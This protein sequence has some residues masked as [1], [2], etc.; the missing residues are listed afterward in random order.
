M[1]REKAL[2]ELKEIRF[3]LNYKVNGT[4]RFDEAL[5]MAIEILERELKT[6]RW[7]LYNDYENMIAYPQCDNCGAVIKLPL[8]ID[9]LNFCPSCGQSKI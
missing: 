2:E 1:T 3:N 7:I 4:S 8:P 6:G 5:N 9:N